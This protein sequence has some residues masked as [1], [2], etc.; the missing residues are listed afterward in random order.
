MISIRSASYFKDNKS[1]YQKVI[2]VK[3]QRNVF[4]INK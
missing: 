2:T 1:S 3:G 4:R